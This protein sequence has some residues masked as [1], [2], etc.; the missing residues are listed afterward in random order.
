MRYTPKFIVK[1]S[2]I[3]LIAGFIVGYSLFQ[4]QNLMSGPVITLEASQKNSD[5]VATI[6]GVAKNVAFITFNGRQIFTDRNG[7][8]SEPFVLSE[9]YNI[10]VV[11]AQDKFGRVKE[12]T[13]ELVFDKK[14]DGNTLSMISPED[15]GKAD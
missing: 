5:D 11:S 15:H 2:L 8:W 13:V 6:Q 3:A 4:A 9:G 14:A 10:I 1:L 7:V 12:K